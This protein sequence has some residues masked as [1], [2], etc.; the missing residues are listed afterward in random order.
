MSWQPA[1]RAARR[2]QE[3]VD[4]IPGLLW[5]FVGT[6][7]L[8][9]LL[10]G[11]RVRYLAFLAL[12]IA[13]LVTVTF[14]PTFQIRHVDVYG[15]L[16]LDRAAV[17]NAAGLIGQNPFTVET[18][19]VR[20]RILALGVPEGV[21]ISFQLPDT[22]VIEVIERQ[23]VYIWKTDT[24][25]YLVSDDGTILGTTRGEHG[26]LVLVD[27]D[28]RPV[29]VGQTID[30]RPFREAAYLRSVLPRVIA[31]PGGYFAYSHDLGVVL[32]LADGLQVA[33]GDDEDLNAKLRVLAPV[34]RVALA[35]NPRP[36]LVDLQSADHPFFR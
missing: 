22:A 34:L 17:A 21:S 24:T 7:R 29:R 28:H 19:A 23:P 30:V 3:R 18:S 27:L 6:V 2:K 35:Q 10:L 9:R 31:L 8:A 33:F 15:T 32:S 4:P 16:L 11:G 20:Q 13:G 14:G 5:I 1:A 25:M 26:R 36:R 12:S